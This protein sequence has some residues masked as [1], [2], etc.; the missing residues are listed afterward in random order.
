MNADPNWKDKQDSSE[1]AKKLAALTTAKIITAGADLVG[2][3]ISALNAELAFLKALP[4]VTDFQFYGAVDVYKV[5][6]IGSKFLV[7]GKYTEAGDGKY[8]I[9]GKSK[10]GNVL[11]E[12]DSSFGWQHI[13]EGHI[14]GKSGKSMFP[15]GMSKSKIKELILE[16][17]DSGKIGKDQGGRV[18]I[19]AAIKPA[20]FGISE[21]EIWINRT[22]GNT[23]ETAYPKSG[24]SVWESSKVAK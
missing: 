3:S 21:M 19:L 16:A 9:L 1:Y 22:N 14:D 12:G 11:Q 7:D 8:R 15:K 23:I 13:V 17:S 10:N 24:A 20:K 18:R 2:L 6:M 4:E 5:Y